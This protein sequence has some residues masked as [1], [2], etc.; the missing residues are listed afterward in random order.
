MPY[1]LSCQRILG[2]EHLT[3]SDPRLK[4]VGA[5]NPGAAMLGDE[6]ILL[7]RVVE[8][9]I[10][11]RD[12]A[13]ASPRYVPG[14]GL[15]IDWL[16]V[17]DLAYEDPRVY[18]DRHTG[19]ERLRFISHLKVVRSTDGRTVSDDLAGPAILPTTAYETYGIEDP[20][21]T[22]IGDVYYITYVGVS[23][24][25]VATCLM[26]TRDFISFERHGI[27]FP[28][29]NKDVLLFPERIAGDYV[30]M[31]RPVP[32]MQMRP[33]E[34]WIAHSPDLIH[35]GRHQHL[36][37]ATRHWE[38]SRIGG[39]T[40]PIRTPRGWL[41][42][43]HASER[44]EGDTGPGAYTAGAL[45]LDLENPRRVL[46]Q[47]HDPVMRPRED[48]ERQGFVNDVVFPT[49]MIEHDQQLWVYYGAAD[50]ATAVA[51]FDQADI[52][53]MLK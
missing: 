10:D 12:D 9:V 46:A 2:P 6:T 39:G 53:A 42:L 26:S 11:D 43:Y 49:A 25:G 29:E 5:F 47:A 24:H 50:C 36:L 23:P 16:P 38:R 20:R 27:I 7:V 13:E 31:H 17:E 30:A 40:P 1:R 48:W 52:L 37:G 28:P 8:Q 15:T 44:R 34:M 19:F 51:V 18:R 32:L 41:S 33:P 21:I 4:V 45:L 35:W 14:Q 3:P 22:R